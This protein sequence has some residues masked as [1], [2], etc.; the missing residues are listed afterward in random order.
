MSRGSRIAAVLV[1]T[2]IGVLLITYYISAYV[3]NKPPAVQAA[4]VNGETKLTLQ[5]VASYGHSP[6]PDWVTYLVQ[7][8]QHQW[9][10]STIFDVPAN[11]LVHVTIYNF[12]GASG[13]RNPFWALA[14]GVGGYAVNGH[15]RQRIFAG[16]TSHTFAVPTLGISVPL[17]GV[18]GSAPNQCS[19]TP[20]SQHT[21][22]HET[23][24]FT[25]KTGK[26]GWFRWQCFVPCAAGWLNG[27]GGPMQTMG[28]MGGYLHVT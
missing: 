6:H 26:A 21:M 1:G 12:D 27:F 14:R 8:A 3:G 2:V 25:I 28:Y 16:S 22:A 7:N 4:T 17:P 5:T 15:Q 24:T 19:V 9:V 23:V 20:C 10:H 18:P 13:L 11:T